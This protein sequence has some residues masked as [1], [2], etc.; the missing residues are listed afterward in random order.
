MRKSSMY[1]TR[2]SH[3]GSSLSSQASVAAQNAKLREKIKEYEAL[4]AIEKLGD[5]YV[6]RLEALDFDCNVMAAAGKGE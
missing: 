2:S 3:A 4:R 6:R 5:E 1:S